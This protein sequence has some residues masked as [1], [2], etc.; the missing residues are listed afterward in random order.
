MSN[1]NA[2]G[3]IAAAMVLL[4]ALEAAIPLRARGA[5]NRAHLVPNLALTALAFATNA[6]L[7]L[8]LVVALARAQSL[9]IGAIPALALPA[10]WSG[11]LAVI[12]FDLAWYATHVSMHHSTLLWRFHRVHHSDPVVDVTTAIRQH[13]GETLVRYAYYAAFG[14]ALGASPAAFAIYRLWSALH[15]LFEHANLRLPLALDS[16]LSWVIA[17]PN[18]HKV[19]HSR[20]P[21]WTNSNYGNILSVFDR[22]CRTFTPARRGVDVDYG[23]DGCDDPALQATVGLLV[24]PFRSVQPSS[25]SSSSRV[26]AVASA[27]PSAASASARLRDCSA[28]TRSSTVSEATSR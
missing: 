1:L 3:W 8:A 17:S 24:L 27:A 6:I 22:A 26:I 25:S 16:A 15:G 13:P 10:A 12:G 2:L 11:A 7:N 23:L 19:H 5:D 9:R 18:M 4:T 28:S 21:Q 14:L 20:A